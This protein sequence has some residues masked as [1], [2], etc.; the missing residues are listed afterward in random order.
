M[1][2]SSLLK[3]SLAEQVVPFRIDERLINGICRRLFV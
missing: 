2:N 3:T 1:Y